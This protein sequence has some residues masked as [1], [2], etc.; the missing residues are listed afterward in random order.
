[1]TQAVNPVLQKAQSL[2]LACYME[3]DKQ[4]IA[5]DSKQ[6]SWCLTYQSG[7]WIL[8]SK[9]VPQINF[10]P[11]EAMKFLERVCQSSG[12]SVRQF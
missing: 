12:A 7:L 11:P 8:F 2:G 1:M 10:E 6:S 9:G 5:P 4:K 3:K